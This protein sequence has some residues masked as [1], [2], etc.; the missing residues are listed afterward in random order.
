MKL[1]QIKLFAR[2]LKNSLRPLFGQNFE[3]TDN[4]SKQ[5]E[6]RIVI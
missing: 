2:D 4:F 3:M 6:P 5:G 1:L